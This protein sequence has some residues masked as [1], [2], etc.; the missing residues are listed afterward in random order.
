VFCDH[1][2]KGGVP[3]NPRGESEYLAFLDECGDHSLTKID[4]DFPLFVLS[5]VIMRR[6]DYV[7][8]ILPEMNA[9]KLAYWDHEGVN[10]H[11]REIRKAYGPFAI[12]QNA[13]IRGPFMERLTGLVRDWPYLLFVVGI[14]KEQ[15]SERYVRAHN[16]Y[17]LALRFVMER[18]VRWME[19][20]GVGLLPI[21]AESRGRNED[22]ALKAAFFD[23]TN[24]GTAYV[25]GAR[26]RERE[27][28]LEFHDKRKN[29]AGIQLADLCAH[30]AAR[31]ILA[32]EQPNR[33]FEAIQGHIFRK[34]GRESGW[35][36]FP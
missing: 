13:T 18:V 6:S 3:V 26:F 25:D 34:G 5:L 17:D 30:P 8:R 4:R 15:L 31:K 12:L 7:E 9:F 16:P 21:V 10:L 14:H 19:Q 22:N 33:A 23:L 29:I 11:S 36:T 1:E 27:F 2:R 28:P 35:K 20:T 32:P 24:E